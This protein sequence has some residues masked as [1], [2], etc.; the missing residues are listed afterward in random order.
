VPIGQHWA[1]QPGLEQAAQAAARP[2]RMASAT[3]FSIG[4]E[5]VQVERSQTRHDVSFGDVL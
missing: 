2:D 1:A 5:F 3:F 4:S